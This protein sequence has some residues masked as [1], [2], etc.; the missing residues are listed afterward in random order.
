MNTLTIT[1]VAHA[2]V[3][4]NFNGRWIL[5]D[6][7]FSQKTGYNPGEPLGIALQDLPK[8]TCVIAS[9]A[10][11]DH[12][13]IDTF[14]AYPDK[15]VTFV[16]KRGMGEQ[17][18]KAGFLN[19]I[20]LDPWQTTTVDSILIT[21]LPAKHAVPE[22][23]YMLQADDFTVFFGA[24]SLLIPEFHEIAQKFPAIDVAFL[25]VNGLTIRPL[26]NRQVVMSAKEAA[27]CCE[28]LKPRLAIPIHYKFTAGWLRD[29][30]LLKYNGTAEEFA[31]SVKSRSLTTTVR[32]LSPGEELQVTK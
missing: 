4:L 22:N 18:I 13:D 32:I 27:Q 23:T 10:H 8:L 30:L 20:E 2:C 25:P 3:L 5:T 7:W 31:A 12:Y 15:N 9:H 16:V 1:R 14:K 6:P 26:F 11:Y 29:R 19:V 17:A 21:A 24:D 28:I